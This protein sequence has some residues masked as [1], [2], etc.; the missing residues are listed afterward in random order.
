[1]NME[2]AWR[3]SR[4]ITLFVGGLAGVAHEVVITQGERPFLLTLFAAMMG[5][6][7]VLGRANGVG[8]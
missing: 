7:L 5:L 3:I 8:D 1:M 6:P 4:D 2:R